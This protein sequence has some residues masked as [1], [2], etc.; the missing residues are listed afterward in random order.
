MAASKMYKGDMYTSGT[1]LFPSDEID[2]MKK[3]KGESARLFALQF[4]KA[5]YAGWGN[6][7]FAY[8][9]FVDRDALIQLRMYGRGQ[10]DTTANYDFWYGRN[11]ANQVIREG[12]MNINWEILPAV[13]K[14]KDSFI[15]RLNENEFVP[16]VYSQDEYTLDQKDQKMMI[17][18][19]KKQMA[20]VFKNAPKNEDGSLVPD[21]MAEF[22]IFNEMGLNKTQA[23]YMWERLIN[24]TFNGINNW[25]LKMKN[26][27]LEDIF[28]V[29]R[30][31]VRD[32]VD[33][34]TQTIRVQYVDPLN[35]IIRLT[36]NGDVIDGGFIELM[37]VQD[38]K[39]ASGLDEATL[40]AI[41]QSASGWYGNPGNTDGTGW[42]YGANYQ[43]WL[44]N[45]AGAVPRTSVGNCEW[46]AFRVPVLHCEYRSVDTEYYRE[47]T[48][49]NDK[50]Y[51]RDTYGK[52]FKNSPNKTTLTKNTINYY[53][54]SWIIGTDHCYNYGLQYDAARPERAEAR[55]S[56]HYYQM[57]D[58]SIVK[59]MKPGLDM[60]QNTWV[61]FQNEIAKAKPDGYL[62]DISVLKNATVGDKIKPKDLIKGIMQTGS[63][64]FSSTA[65]RTNLPINPHM[66]SPVIPLPGG[67]EKAVNSFAMAYN[68]LQQILS[69]M[70]GMTP[71]FTGGS[72]I[73]EGARVNQGQDAAS[74]SLLKTKVDAYKF[75]RESVSLNILLR[76]Q[77]IF[78]HNEKMIEA[79]RGILGSAGV[80]LLQEA[81]KKNYSQYGMKMDV[82]TSGALYN[83]IRNMANIAMQ[84]GKN[85]EPGI[86]FN[87]YITIMTMLDNNVEVK[88]IQAYLQRLVDNRNKAYAEQQMQM[89]DN[90]NKGLAMMEQQK[91]MMQDALMTKTT[92]EKIRETLFTEAIKYKFE[93]MKMPEQAMMNATDSALN[94]MIEA[95]LNNLMGQYGGGQTAA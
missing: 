2:P 84:P 58:P 38:L 48:K 12:S 4:A 75:I 78:R 19:L 27:L 51:S 61:E 83:D 23:E 47:T 18:M 39:K 5:F 13:L 15:S 87:E 49:G 17:D 26:R 29:G 45:L 86:N 56:F 94:A 11:D 43:W 60:V 1:Y 6:G 57:E 41:A 62:F 36:T 64:I 55:C 31:C 80:A 89:Q 42:Q 28:S 93:I 69:D 85:G 34:D 76:G 59:R 53:T 71:S 37:T 67:I 3:R 91:A 21:S 95:T 16:R 54:C 50:L 63:G 25:D 65:K 24:F 30:L 52:V 79:Y 10:Q 8:S 22:E 46:Y 73:P 35:T 44:S 9:R 92:D 72:E 14:F 88:F 81:S 90:Q 20:V 33:P 74:Q 68:V 40:F 70:S 32:Y 7:N 66:G 77:V 82:K